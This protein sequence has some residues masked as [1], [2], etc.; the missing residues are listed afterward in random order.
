MAWKIVAEGIN[1]W[2][3]KATVRDME[4]PKGSKMRIIIDLKAPLGWVFDLAGAENS[5]R[6]VVPE[7]ME[8]VDVYGEGSQGIIDME[9]DPAWLLPVLT[10]IR[11]H[12]LTIVIAGFVLTAII[13]SIIILVKIA[14]APALPTAM[15][16]IVG[17][18]VVIGI[19]AGMASKRVRLRPS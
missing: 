7:G 4:L 19:V 18:L 6:A 5:F 16:A 13:A 3:L 15:L 12:W 9:A 8:L 17:G 2:D 10:A 11:V 14:V 1:I